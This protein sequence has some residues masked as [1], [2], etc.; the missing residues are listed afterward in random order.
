MKTKDQ[1]LFRKYQIFFIPQLNKTMAEMS[2]EEK[3][4]LSHRAK[5]LFPMIEWIDNNLL[6]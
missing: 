1:I 6:K 4:T 5:A 2:L 3:N